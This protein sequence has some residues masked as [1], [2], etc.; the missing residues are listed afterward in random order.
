MLS[1]LSTLR[2]LALCPLV[3]ASIVQVQLLRKITAKHDDFKPNAIV[4]IGANMGAW[5]RGARELF[6]A[7]KLLLME[8]SPQHDETLK[9]V[10]SEVGNAEY[11]ICVVSA[12]DGETV[13]FWQGKNTGNSMFKENSNFYAKDIP[14]KRTTHTLDTEIENSFLK[15]EIID[16]VKADVQGAELV[17]FQGATRTL[18]QATFVFFEGS[19]IE[20]NAGGSCWHDVDEFL[21]SQGFYFY[22]IGGLNNDLKGFHTYGLGQFDGRCLMLLCILF[23]PNGHSLTSLCSLLICDS[24]VYQA[25]FTEASSKDER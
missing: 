13:D 25:R 18:S 1:L 19:A 8:A 10:V 3:S 14:V 2:L 9:Q 16:V 5:S 12:T 15:G 24:P 17:V 11:K 7:T 4:D 23:D 22:D 21:R 20:Y 6:P